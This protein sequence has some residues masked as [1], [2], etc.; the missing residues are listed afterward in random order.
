MQYFMVLIVLIFTTGC[1]VK[2]EQNAD[3]KQTQAKNIYALTSQ[4]KALDSSIDLKEAQRAATISILYP[5]S[6]AKS[7][8]LTSP[9]LWHNSLINMNIK[10]RGFCYHFAQDLAHMLKKEHF[11]T[12]RIRWADHKNGQYWEHNALVITAINQPF[13][14][15]LILDAWRNSGKLYWDHVSHDTQYSWTENIRKSQYFGTLPH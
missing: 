8:E 12:L 1:S 11:Q 6:L 9:P 13:K 4:I 14:Q 15:G 10:Q 2:Y 7:Y 3:F 5:L